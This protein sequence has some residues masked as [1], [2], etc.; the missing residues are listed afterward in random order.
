MI[1]EDQPIRLAARLKRVRA[2][3]PQSSGLHKLVLLRDERRPIS[4]TASKTLEHL[5]T[6]EQHDAVRFPVAPQTMA[7]LD[8]M[9]S[10]LADAQS[11]DLARGAETIGPETVIDWLRQNMADALKELADML[12]TPVGTHAPGTVRPTVVDHSVYFAPLQEYL[13]EHCVVRWDDAIAQLGIPGA[14]ASELLRSVGAR[15]DLFGLIPGEPA[16][17]FAVRTS[18][19]ATSV[20]PNVS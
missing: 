5:K 17:L 7:A 1:C 4:C 18:A 6:L 14:Q 12:V 15:T 9:R 13:D 10:L 8:A 19:S 20:L 16:V 2:T 11:G 3:H